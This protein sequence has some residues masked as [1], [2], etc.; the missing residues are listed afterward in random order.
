MT[1]QLS[2]HLPDNTGVIVIFNI[3]VS[4]YLITPVSSSSLTLLSQ[5]D[6]KFTITNHKSQLQRCNYMTLQL[7]EHL[8]NNTGVIVIFNI[9]VTKISQIDLVTPE[10]DISSGGL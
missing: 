3:V 9:G 10:F 5:I 6:Q 8:P 1:L 4:T 7:S 2:E